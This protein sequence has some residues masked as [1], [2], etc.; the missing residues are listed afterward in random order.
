MIAVKVGLQ[1]DRRKH[2]MKRVI[3]LLLAAATLAAASPVL[4]DPYDHHDDRRGGWDHRDGDRRDWGDHR[5]WRHHHERYCFWRHH[6]Q[7][8]TW[9]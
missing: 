1:L 8:C 7:V 6:H 5:G 9:R 3:T 4:A 2:F